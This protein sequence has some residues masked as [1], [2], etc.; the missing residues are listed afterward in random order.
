M[1]PINWADILILGSNLL[2]LGI[3]IGGLIYNFLKDIFTG[4]VISSV[5]GFNLVMMTYDW[6]SHR[7][8]KN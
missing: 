4:I 1:K 2:G 3:G 8:K 7:Q 5:C 6:Y